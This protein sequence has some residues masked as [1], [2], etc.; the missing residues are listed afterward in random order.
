[1]V[2]RGE[3]RGGDERFRVDAHWQVEA[4]QD[5]LLLVFNL[6]G[7][8]KVGKDRGH[9]GSRMRTVYKPWELETLG[10]PD[11]GTDREEKEGE[12]KAKLAAH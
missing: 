3:G 10:F 12:L 1:M 7:E 4:H 6:L 9:C 8:G 2:R 11:Q 5:N